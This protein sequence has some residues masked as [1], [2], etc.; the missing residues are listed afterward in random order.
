MITRTWLA[1]GVGTL[2]SAMSTWFGFL[3][4]VDSVAV[5]VLIVAVGLVLACCSVAAFSQVPEPLRV[6]LRSAMY[7]LGVGGVM[8]VL[9]RLADS[10]LMLMLAPL[11]STGVGGAFALAPVGDKPRT[12]ARLAAMIPVTL[13]AGVVHGADP[14][15][16]GIFMPLTP[17]ISVGFAERLFAGTGEDP[18]EDAREDSGTP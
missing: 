13:L 12:L 3:A 1:V 18:R 11:V 7:G 14:L 17:L 8:L 15:V 4:G 2:I 5:A 6:G 16:F 10:G 9:A